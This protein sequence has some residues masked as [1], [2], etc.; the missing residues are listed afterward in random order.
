MKNGSILAQGCWAPAE[1]RERQTWCGSSAPLRFKC[2]GAVQVPRC[3]S[4]APVRFKC[5]S[6]CSGE[7]QTLCGSSAPVRCKCTCAVQV[8]L[9]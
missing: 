1:T 7:R 6:P 3:G 5:P 2:P 9:C 4:S 8:L